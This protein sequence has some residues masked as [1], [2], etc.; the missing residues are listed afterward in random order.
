MHRKFL[1]LLFVLVIIINTAVPA[2]AG[3]FSVPELTTTVAAKYTKAG[4]TESIGGVGRSDSFEGFITVDST[5]TVTTTEQFDILWEEFQ[6][7]VENFYTLLKNFNSESSDSLYVSADASDDRK[8]DLAYLQ[9]KLSSLRSNPDNIINMYGTSTNGTLDMTELKKMLLDIEFVS[10]KVQVLGSCI[11]NVETQ[12]KNSK[13]STDISYPKIAELISENA[14]SGETSYTTFDAVLS[15]LSSEGISRDDFVNSL[16]LNELDDTKRSTL[17]LAF[18]LVDLW[19]LTPDYEVTNTSTG[20]NTGTSTGTDTSTSTGGFLP[21][22][23]NIGVGDMYSLILNEYRMNG[24]TYG[25][26]TGLASEKLPMIQTFASQAGKSTTPEEVYE[27]IFSQTPT[28]SSNPFTFK[29]SRSNEDTAGGT[30]TLDTYRDSWR[31]FEG[32]VSV[33]SDGVDLPDNYFYTLVFMLYKDN[34]I[35]IVQNRYSYKLTADTGDSS[36]NDT[37][38]S[39][40]TTSSASDSNDSDT[41]ESTTSSDTSESTTN[42]ASSSSTSSSTAGNNQAK[43]EALKQWNEDE[44]DLYQFVIQRLNKLNEFYAEF[45]ITNKYTENIKNTIDDSIKYI[46]EQLSSVG[47]EPLTTTKDELDQNL[48]MYNPEL[49]ILRDFINEYTWGYELNQDYK[50]L[51][52]WTACFTPFETNIYDEGTNTTHLSQSA[53]AKYSKYSKI[54]QPLS[55]ITSTD[56]TYQAL[57]QNST[58]QLEYCTLRDFIENTDKGDLFLFANDVS[59]DG[60][61]DG[62]SSKAIITNVVSNDGTV[63]SVV[64]EGDELSD[65]PVDSA[66]ITTS[67]RYFGPVYASSSTAV[68]MDYYGDENNFRDNTAYSTVDISTY[69]LRP[70]T[71]NTFLTSG[72]T[73]YDVSTVGENLNSDILEDIEENKED[74]EDEKKDDAV[75]AEARGDTSEDTDEDTGDDSEEEM[76]S[77]IHYSSTTLLTMQISPRLLYMNFM[78]AHNIIADGEYLESGLDIDLDQ[79]LFMDF[80]GNIVTDSGYIVVPAAANAT[81][82]NSIYEY[83]IYTAAFLN[84]YP[85]IKMD[86]DNKISLTGNDADKYYLYALDTVT[87]END[88]D[89]EV[90]LCIGK[91]SE[92]LTG[93]YNRPL[94]LERLTTSSYLLSGGDADSYNYNDYIKGEGTDGESTD[95]ADTNE[96]ETNEES[97]NEEDTNEETEEVESVTEVNA[98]VIDKNALFEDSRAITDS[99]RLSAGLVKTT[100]TSQITSVEDLKPSKSNIFSQLLRGIKTYSYDDLCLMSVG[101]IADICS[102]EYNVEL[103]DEVIYGLFDGEDSPSTDDIREY[104]Y[105]DLPEWQQIRIFEIVDQC[106]LNVGGEIKYTQEVKA[107]A[108]MDDLNKMVDELKQNNTQN[109]SEEAYRRK[110]MN[111]AYLMQFSNTI[112]TSTGTVVT[113]PIFYG[114]GDNS[115]VGITPANVSLTEY[116]WGNYYEK[117]GSEQAIQGMDCSSLVS[118]VLAR[119]RCGYAPVGGSN[120][121]RFTGNMMEWYNS[122]YDNLNKS[123]KLPEE[124]GPIPYSE[125]NLENAKPGDVLLSVADTHTAFYWGKLNGTHYIFDSNGT[126]NKPKVL[127][128]DSNGNVIDPVNGDPAGDGVDVTTGDPVKYSNGNDMVSKGPTLNRNGGATWEYILPNPVLALAAAENVFGIGSDSSATSNVVGDAVNVDIASQDQLE[129]SL[130]IRDIEGKPVRELPK[131]REAVSFMSEDNWYSGAL[132]QS[133]DKVAV[134][135]PQASAPVVSLDVHGIQGRITLATIPNEPLS[136]EWLGIMSLNYNLY[137]MWEATPQNIN[138]SG[139]TVRM[140]CFININTAC[141]IMVSITEGSPDTQVYNNDGTIY[142]P[143]LLDKSSMTSWLGRIFEYIYNKFICGTEKNL[144]A[145]I[146][147]ID[148]ERVLTYVALIVQPLILLILIGMSIFLILSLALRTINGNPI[149]FGE[150]ASSFLATVLMIVFVMHYMIPFASFTFDH[151]QRLAIGDEAL[152]DTVYNVESS[153][154]SEANTY[155]SDTNEVFR[156]DTRIKIASLT[157]DEAMTLREQIDPDR[158]GI[159]SVFYNPA[160]DMTK[161]EVSDTVYIQGLGLYTNTQDLLS[162]NSI[163]LVRNDKNMLELYHDPGDSTLFAN[164]TPY[165]HFCESIVYTLNAYAN[166][167]SN[168]YKKLNY[169]KTATTTGKC[170]SYF[171]SIYFISPEDMLNYIGKVESN[172]ELG[173]GINESMIEDE[174]IRYGLSLLASEPT[175]DSDSGATEASTSEEVTEATSESDSLGTALFGDAETSLKENESIEDLTYLGSDGKVAYVVTSEGTYLSIPLNTIEVYA[176]LYKKMGDLRDWL[177]LKKILYLS[178]NIDPFREEYYE[179]VANSRWY[180]DLNDTLT[181]EDLAKLEDKIYKVNDRTKKF[182]LSYLSTDNS[183]VL[184]KISDEN[185]IK[186]IALK[187]T[188]EYNREFNTADKSAYPTYVDASTGNNDFYSKSVYIPRGDIFTTKASSIGSYI[189]AET[190]EVGLIGILIERVLFLAR[191]ILKYISFIGIFVSM[192]VLYLAFVLHFRSITTQAFNCFVTGIIIMGISLV[193]IAQMRIGIYL[194]NNTLSTSGIIVYNVIMA[195]ILTVILFKM[196]FRLVKDYKGLVVR[197]VQGPSIREALRAER[198]S[199]MSKRAH[200]DM[201]DDD[202]YNMPE[203]DDTYI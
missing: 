192:L 11:L 14:K 76:A 175:T 78:L 183:N 44:R 107:D 20:T 191:V 155:F 63:S 51:F 184:D 160:Y 129:S 3:E 48:S 23:H 21:L 114:Y 99:D 5:G 97:T 169:T 79:I 45:G 66:Q 49:S 40:L 190:G 182:I 28:S 123:G 17:T 22:G 148:N 163:N 186:L 91:G 6:T 141:G 85:D 178:E 145:L 128:V 188:I 90:T 34:F 95:K 187:A 73:S 125:A 136:Y 146:P 127:L 199:T 170:N 100:A 59:Q 196:V 109:L 119:F 19:S 31:A 13:N 96:E 152:M 74:S 10:L 30:P 1:S 83:P 67:N 162:I 24:N 98:R 25:N 157:Q 200:D 113:E 161:S 201:E 171:N 27:G 121:R 88:S 143:R 153:N 131:N 137:K 103:S 110:M 33:V 93:S 133:G 50:E 86:S 154:R 138:G 65:S 53:K 195:V 116:F 82:Y 68:Y 159:S 167:T 139:S 144:W 185:L 92:Q 177:G 12:L 2:G 39:E 102:Q 58:R 135:V 149:T 108:S 29:P 72:I 165:F 174:N 181:D 168:S 36:D 130:G 9:S 158:V 112:E 189:L 142:D 62:Y 104:N 57:L 69:Y 122:A 84:S 202:D 197:V 105:S 198:Y 150:I 80:L 61:L 38:T 42:S 118:H 47:L 194:A 18:D 54:R 81:R 173:R 16:F 134:Y 193:D 35:S 151:G 26:G 41:S 156:A 46:S 132:S 7:E 166:N 70:D 55:Y 64:S 52:A 124:I 140:D 111:Y 164:Y 179:E 120:A 71:A 147:T 87:D 56:M 180:P 77:T 37:D 60:I 106:R 101:K 94:A 32:G 8:N 117:N 115:T 126:K 15:E 172:S 176:T 4:S 75:G 43:L 203:A 89:S